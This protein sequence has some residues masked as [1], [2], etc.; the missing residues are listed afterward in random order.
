MQ[1]FHRTS[2]NT[3]KKPGGELLREENTMFRKFTRR[4]ALK[5]S[6]LALGGLAIGHV[7]GGCGD[8]SGGTS[9]V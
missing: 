8:S 4:D 7:L 2:T 3:Y 5:A 6:G 1:D 9:R